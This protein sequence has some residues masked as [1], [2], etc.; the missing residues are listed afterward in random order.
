MGLQTHSLADHL[1]KRQKFCDNKDRLQKLK[2]IVVPEDQSDDIDRKMLA[3]TVKADQPELYNILRTLLHYYAEID[4]ID[5][6]QPVPFWDQIEKFDLAES[7]W[8]FIKK[9]F[10]YTEELPSLENLL[11]RLLVTDFVQHLHGK[12]PS[13]EHLVLPQA[14]R[15]NAVVCLAQWRDSSSKGSS[16]DLLSK[17]VAQRINLSGQLHSFDIDHLID[18]QTFVDVE[19]EIASNLK[20]RVLSTADAIKVEDIREIATKRQS[21]HWGFAKFVWRRFNSSQGTSCSL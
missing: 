1:K 18:V 20:E 6:R 3:V 7:F 4:E 11:I 17:Y 12:A 14:G 5:L 16:Y 8:R 10:G 2:A 13:L 21:G 15:A 9:A 19:N